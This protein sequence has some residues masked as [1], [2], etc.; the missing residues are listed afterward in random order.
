MTNYSKLTISR[1]ATGSAA[2]Q[3]CLF[4]VI[5]QKLSASSLR[6]LNVDEYTRVLTNPTVFIISSRRTPRFRVVHQTQNR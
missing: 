4:L 6:F 2:F 3:S 1:K 5:L